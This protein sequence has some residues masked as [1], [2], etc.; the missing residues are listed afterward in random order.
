MSNTSASKTRSLTMT[1]LMVLMAIS[2]MAS[3]EA[4]HNQNWFGDY[5]LHVDGTLYE[6]VEVPWP[7]DVD[8][9]SCTQHSWDDRWSCE[10]DLDGDGNFNYPDYN[11]DMD[12]CDDST[13]SWV[14]V[15]DY[16]KPLMDEGNYSLEYYVSG[17]DPDTNY[18][19]YLNVFVNDFSDPFDFHIH[20][21]EVFESDSNGEISIEIDEMYW[22]VTN[23]TCDGN[24][25]IRLNWVDNGTEA[26]QSQDYFAGWCEG[27][28][29][30]TT[31]LD[32]EEWESDP[33]YADNIIDCEMYGA[34]W[35]CSADNHDNDGEADRF[36]LRFD[37]DQCEEDASGEWTCIQYTTNP[38][39]WPGDHTLE[40]IAS[41]LPDFSWKMQTQVWDSAAEDWIEEETYF[42]GTSASVSYTHLTLPTICSV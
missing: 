35:Y 41:G 2:P 28:F 3:V 39:V 34:N 23:S 12:Y 6:E 21:S 4:D 42:N 16:T 31:E 26:L 18:T 30:V 13:G 29:H 19:A 10:I 14:C 24:S 22:D 36:M 17:L 25:Q 37:M 33:N 1:L 38:L 40:W 5:E 32:G 27:E 20:T 15:Y 9:L 11:Q 8:I 7:S